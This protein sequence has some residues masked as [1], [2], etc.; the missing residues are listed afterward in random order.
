MSAREEGERGKKKT[1]TSS[2]SRSHF[3]YIQ[4]NPFFQVQLAMEEEEVEEASR[5]ERII[6]AAPVS[7]YTSAAAGAGASDGGD[8]GEENPTNSTR[9]LLVKW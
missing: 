2:T 6:K 8:G 4:K 7:D 1:H 3:F 5:V 9:K